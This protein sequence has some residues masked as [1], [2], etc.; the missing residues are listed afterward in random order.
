MKSR[1]YEVVLQ[2]V[3]VDTISG[4]YSKKELIEKLYQM[5]TPWGTSIIPNSIDICRA[6]AVKSKRSKP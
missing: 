2:I 4:L 5:A 6:P 3:E 1:V